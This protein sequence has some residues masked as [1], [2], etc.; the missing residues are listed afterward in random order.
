[1]ERL[2]HRDLED[3]KWRTQIDR[4]VIIRHKTDLHFRKEIHP[5]IEEVEEEDVV[6][7]VH[8]E[9]EDQVDRTLEGVMGVETYH[10]AIGMAER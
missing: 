2:V 7:V 3:E 5:W 8:S 9:E 1:M 4:L 6:D 10:L